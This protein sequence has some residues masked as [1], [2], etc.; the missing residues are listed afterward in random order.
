MKMQSKVGIG[1][2]IYIFISCFLYLN[3][4]AGTWEQTGGRWWY[5]EGDSYSKN[6]WKWI[7]GDADGY[8]Q[9]YYF[10]SDGWLLTDTITPDGCEVDSSGAW[11]IE[12]YVEHMKIITGVLKY[13]SRD[14]AF[15]TATREYQKTG[16]PFDMRNFVSADSD[17]AILEMEPPIFTYTETADKVPGGYEWKYIDIIYLKEASILG[18]T[19][20]GESEV[21][22]DKGRYY[23]SWKQY[24]N[25]EVD[26]LLP[27]KSIIETPS[28]ANNPRDKDYKYG[29]AYIYN[30]DIDEAPEVIHLRYGTF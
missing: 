30:Y 1:I 6:G 12:G 18:V 13:Y 23:D 22:Y 2:I 21:S 17:F 4:I 9:C 11:T 5:K 7:D 16:S 29:Y 19:T 28:E 27:V 24:E 3:S 26:I 10:D 8:A 25:Q 20:P 15:E 14:K